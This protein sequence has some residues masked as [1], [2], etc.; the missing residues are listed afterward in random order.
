VSEGALRL[1]AG[2]EADLRAQ[3]EMVLAPAV[4]DLL[5]ELVAERVRVELAER[6]AHANANGS[7]WLTLEQA[8]E[9]LGCSADAV[10]MRVKRGRLES[11]RQGR[12]VY[13]SAESVERLSCA[14]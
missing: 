12:R 7:T 1:L 4:V 6:D 2:R 5:E 11:R 8:G 10:R 9:Q 14:A 13:V 3:L